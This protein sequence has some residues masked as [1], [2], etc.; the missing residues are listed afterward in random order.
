MAVP[1]AQLFS[2]PPD[3]APATNRNTQL[4]FQDLFTQLNTN[5]GAAVASGT[6][7]RLAYYTSS[8]AIGALAAITASRA[9]A[10]DANGLPVAASTTTT[11]LNGL[12]G[13]T[14]SRAIVTTAGGIL[15]AAT[16]TATEIG[17]VNG[18]TSAI[19]TQLNGK[20][21]TALS[22]LASVAIN[23]TLVS[24]SNGVDDLGTSGIRWKDLYLA[25]ST[26]ITAGQGGS[27]V[28]VLLSNTSNT[29][30]SIAYVDLNVAGSSA[31][32]AYCKAT[33]T[34]VTNW[35]WGLDNSDGDSWVLS[36]SDVVGTNNA[37]RADGTTGAVALRGTTTNDSAA[38]GFVGE[39]IS[40]VASGVSL[41]NNTYVNI[42]SISLTVGDW[43][44][45]GCIETDS[46]TVTRIIGAISA[47][48]G[49]TTTDHVVGDNVLNGFLPTSAYTSGISIPCWRVSITSTTTIYLKSRASFA[50]GA[51]T[52]TGRLSARRIR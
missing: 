1:F 27:Y 19:Q 21:N 17:Y 42:T 24:D 14:A 43:D 3:E 15:T 40:A 33:V 20:A 31:G 7:N 11:E 51:A 44:V 49:N 22:N 28:R 36:R 2:F 47:F 4:V 10:S 50:S 30:S 13:L 41:T 6:T 32:D 46:T 5:I 16:T 18:V 8:T 34:G 23:T 12:N 52:S 37:I 35:V 38:A 29:A 25:S 9:L 48:S 45:T 26:D 39:Y